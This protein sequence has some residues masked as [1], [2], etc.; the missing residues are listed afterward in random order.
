MVL[1]IPELNWNFGYEKLSIKT[2]LWPRNSFR[3]FSIFEK[4]SLGNPIFIWGSDLVFEISGP[5]Q[6]EEIL[7]KSRIIVYFNQLKGVIH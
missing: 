3:N 5:G 2:I 6:A 1:K 4:E 7:P